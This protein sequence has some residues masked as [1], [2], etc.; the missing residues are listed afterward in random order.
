MKFRGLFSFSRL[1]LG[2]KYV[3]NGLGLNCIS[4]LSCILIVDHP[5]VLSLWDISNCLDMPNGNNWGRDI[6]IDNG[7]GKSHSLGNK[8]GHHTN[9]NCIHSKDAKIKVFILQHIL[10]IKT[11]KFVLSVHVYICVCVNLKLFDC[12]ILMQGIVCSGLAYY[13]QGLVM[14]VKGPIFMTA[15]YPLCMVIVAVM[16]SIILAEQ[17]YL[18]RYLFQFI[19]LVGSVN[20]K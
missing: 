2:L 9:G 6:G 11:S 5:K 8:V 17:M 7:E 4:N 12:V 19:N 13:I 14:K 20:M 3:W 18:G 10:T 16:G 1:A 15:F